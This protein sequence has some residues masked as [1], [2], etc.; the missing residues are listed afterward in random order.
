MAIRTF[1]IFLEYDDEAVARRMNR[2][3]FGVADWV[4]RDRLKSIRKELVGADVKGADIVNVHFFENAARCMRC[5]TWHRRAN[6]IELNVVYDLQS[7]LQGD[8]VDN[9]K[10]L[11]R[12][13][14][15]LCLSAPWPQVLAIGRA[16]EPELTDE[17]AQNLRGSLRKWASLVDRSAGLN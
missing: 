16:L 6:A 15:T 14:A 11:L 9:V 4:S 8:P 3:H 13:V 1:R 12:V 7:L 17:E 5:N 10:A 2:A